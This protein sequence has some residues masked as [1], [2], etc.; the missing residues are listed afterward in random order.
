M[1]PWKTHKK[2]IIEYWNFE[3]EEINCFSCDH[4]SWIDA[5]IS[6][7]LYVYVQYKTHGNVYTH[8]ISGYD[9]YFFDEKNNHF[10]GWNDYYDPDYFYGREYRLDKDGEKHLHTFKNKPAHIKG[11]IVKFGIE[12]EEPWDRLLGFVGG[13]RMV[14][15]CLDMLLTTK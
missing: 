5:P 14:S 6:N 9:F 11:D 10:G 1:K 13:S 7:V 2:W 4:G 12:L 15:S 8:I 3:D